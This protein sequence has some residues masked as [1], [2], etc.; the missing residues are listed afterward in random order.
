MGRRRSLEQTTSHG[1]RKR[2]AHRLSALATC[3]PVLVFLI[4]VP[5]RGRYRLFRVGLGALEVI[6]DQS[7]ELCCPVRLAHVI[8][9][10]ENTF[11]FL[12]VKSASRTFAL[13]ICSQP[14]QRRCQS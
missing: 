8:N 3:W 5:E 7:E 13:Q 2:K 12:S 6:L 14:D 9:H 11:G 1:H 4:S 10:H